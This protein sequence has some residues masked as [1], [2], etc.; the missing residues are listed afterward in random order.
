MPRYKLSGND[1]EAINI[2]AMGHCECDRF[3]HDHGMSDCPR[4]IGEKARFVFRVG[5]Q[6][7]HPS[8][9]NVIIVCPTCHSYIDREKGIVSG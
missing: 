4:K 8:V 9:S 6:H 2:R 5:V 7:V 3:D 1:I